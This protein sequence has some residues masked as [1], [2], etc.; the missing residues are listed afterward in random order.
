MHREDHGTWTLA[1]ARTAVELQTG[2]HGES[3]HRPV[4]KT[5]SVCGRHECR[6]LVQ[7]RVLAF[8]LRNAFGD[9]RIRL[10]YE[11]VVDLLAGVEVVVHRGAAQPGARGDCLKIGRL[12]AAFVD[13]F[14]RRTKN[15]RSCF[16]RVGTHRTAASPAGRLW[17]CVTHHEQTLWRLLATGQQVIERKR[18]KRYSATP[19]SVVS[20]M[21]RRYASA[22][23]ATRPASASRCARVVQAG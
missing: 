19:G 12:I 1:Q 20:S 22:A 2:H 5:R 8:C 23:S 3:Q 21:A 7:Q 9:N 17:H 11:A 4:R 18:R 14:A 15:A 16:G 13:H 6:Q 10:R